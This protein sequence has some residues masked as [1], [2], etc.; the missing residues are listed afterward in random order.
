M[1]RILRFSNK[2]L[3]TRDRVIITDE[4]D[5]VVAVAYSSPLNWPPA[6]TIHYGGSEIRIQRKV[7]VFPGSWGVS[8]TAGDFTL[9]RIFF[10]LKRQ[11]R[12]SGGV[13]DGARIAGHVWSRKLDITQGNERIALSHSR[14]VTLRDIHEV[15]IVSN[16]TEAAPFVL[17]VIATLMIDKR[18]DDLV[19]ELTRMELD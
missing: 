5:R 14:I 2:L 8:G 11:Y 12:V 3:T 19:T 4:D 7:F 13:F 6:W 1:P 15:E 9:R 10:S 16:H 18:V 17:S